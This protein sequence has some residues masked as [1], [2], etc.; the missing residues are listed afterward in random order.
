MRRHSLTCQGYH[1]GYT[2]AMARAATFELIGEH[3][4][5]DF[6]NTVGW[7]GDPA[8]RKDL[9]LSFEDLVAWAKAVKL[10]GTADIRTLMLAAQRDQARA[11]GS[12]RRARRLRE[13][14]ARVLVAAGGDA[15]PAARDVRLI[16]AFLAAA[17]RHRR[18]EVRGAA[19]AWSWASRESDAFDALLW[20]I[21][22]AGADLLAS[23]DRTQIRECRGEGCG[24]LFLDTSRNRRRR[25]CTMQSCGNRAKARRF[26]ERAREKT[27]NPR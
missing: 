17:L 19:F 9:L 27:S 23:D 5:L 10:V 26:Y 11:L 16:N 1:I 13:V 14:L 2:E 21:V 25:W 7:R 3:V 6:V 4:T 15:R 22:L 18:L 8:R 20:P 24:W 12:L